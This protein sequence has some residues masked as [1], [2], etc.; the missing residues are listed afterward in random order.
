MPKGGKGKKGKGKGK[1]PSGPNLL[2]LPI[3]V[4]NKA[5]SGDV[6][7]AL[8]WLDGGGNVDA[9]HGNPALPDRSRTL[10]MIASRNGH[11]DFVVTLLERGAAVNKQDSNGY[12]ALMFAAG[13]GR[14]T[15]VQRLLWAGAAPRTCNFVGRNALQWVEERAD[16]SPAPG[17]AD[18]ARLII[19]HI[20][21][22]TE[23][24]R[25]P[26]P[27]GPGIWAGI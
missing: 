27:P 22:H 16:H 3:D 13:Y 15:V 23:E 5:H 12:T 18:C 2:N 7:G 17:H 4:R 9:T 25:G 6:P 1:A 24:L 14:P 21:D 26:T 19:K 11:E 8:Q 10:L 20:G